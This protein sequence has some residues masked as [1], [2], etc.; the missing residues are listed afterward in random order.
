MVHFEESETL[1]IPNE[2][3][4][5]WLLKIASLDYL[6]LMAILKTSL[7]IADV[8]FLS[9]EHSESEPESEYL[10]KKCIVSL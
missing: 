9:K 2:A 4:I 3:K 8:T 10:Y 6:V 1:K 7:C 5:V